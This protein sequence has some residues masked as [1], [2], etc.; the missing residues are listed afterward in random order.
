MYRF[1]HRLRAVI[2]SAISA[3]TIGIGMSLLLDLNRT[4]ILPFFPD[5][6][7]ALVVMLVGGILLA[8]VLRNS[9]K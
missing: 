5:V 9:T 1:V 3:A 4:I 6:A 2:Y 7:D 8:E